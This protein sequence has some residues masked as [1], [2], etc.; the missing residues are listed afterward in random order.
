MTT[1]YMGIGGNNANSGTSWAQRKATLNGVEDIPVQA[2]DTVYIGA[3]TYRDSMTCDVSGSSGSPISYIGDIDGSHTD[4]VGGVVRITNTA[5]DEKSYGATVQAI[6]MANAIDY[7]MFSNLLIDGF[8]T[9][10]F[11]DN[12]G[13]NTIINNCIFYGTTGNYH[14]LRFDK[15]PGNL[16]MTNCIFIAGYHGGT[17]NCVNLA[18]TDKNDASYLFQNCLFMGM[19]SGVYSNGCGNVTVKN[20]LFFHTSIGVR[21]NAV[22]TSYPAIVNNNLFYGCATAMSSNAAD[23]ITENYN[24]INGCDVARKNVGVGAQSLAYPVNFDLRW[25]VELLFNNGT[26]VTPFDLASYSALIDVAG[27]TPTTADLR[28]TTKQGTEREWGALEYDST[29]DIEAGTGGGGA[30]SI[31]PISGRLWL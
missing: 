4:G 14:I 25:A 28:G 6:K 29:L 30:V 22:N 3:G 2:G 16:T 12:T 5:A 7:R 20:S 21:T 23:Q 15:A 24:N 17:G 18:G 26:M 19:A 10:I 8:P 1:Y 9:A 27:T 31:Q 13:G 11:N